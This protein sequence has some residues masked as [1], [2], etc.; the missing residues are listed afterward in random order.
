MKSMCMYLVPHEYKAPAPPFESG[1]GPRSTL[2]CRPDVFESGN[3]IGSDCGLELGPGCGRGS[4]GAFG[5]GCGKGCGCGFG[6]GCGKGRGCVVG[7]GLGRG[8]GCGFGSGFGRGCGCGCGFGFGSGCGFGSG[9]GCGFGS[10]TCCNF[11]CGPNCTCGFG[12]WRDSGPAGLAIIGCTHPA[13]TTT[14]RRHSRTEWPRIA[15]DG[16]SLSL[17]LSGLGVI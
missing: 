1:C 15:M 16:T 2:D 5:S 4:G 12:F 3:G 13:P 14:A 6:F 11:R 9:I 7:S 8:C 10:G 17:S